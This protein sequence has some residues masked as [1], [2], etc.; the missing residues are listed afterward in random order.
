LWNFEMK[1]CET[2]NDLRLAK[3]QAIQ[4]VGVAFGKGQQP[5]MIIHKSKY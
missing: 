1:L 5:G 4:N 3:I 2:E